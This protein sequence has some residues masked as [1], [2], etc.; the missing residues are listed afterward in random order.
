M[1]AE[2]LLQVIK[3]LAHRQTVDADA[4]RQAFGVIMRGEG[5]PAQVAALLMALRVKG[6][7][8]DEIAGVV[9]ALRDAMVVL[10]L[11]NP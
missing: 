6:E 1:S 5:S 4:L 11:A 2:A 10:P 7:T 3:R 9:Q 8:A